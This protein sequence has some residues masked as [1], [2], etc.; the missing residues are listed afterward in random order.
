MVRQGSIGWVDFSPTKGH[1]Q[2]GRRP[3]LVVSADLFNQSC[4][5]IVWAIPITNTTG[6]LGKL[7][8]PEGLPV[9]GAFILSQIK[10]L[11][12]NARSFTPI[13]EIPDELLNDIIGRLA[14]VLYG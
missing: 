14:A 1:E 11:D 7:N 4:G 5:G 8:V 10:A 2:A 6:G 3:A 9:T 13:C 12:V